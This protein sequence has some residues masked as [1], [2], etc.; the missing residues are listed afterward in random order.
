MR[1]SFSRQV[2]ISFVFLAKGKAIFAEGH[3]IPYF[4]ANGISGIT[5]VIVSIVSVL[6]LPIPSTLILRKP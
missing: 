3:G 2:T 4:S 5:F 1:I 6:A